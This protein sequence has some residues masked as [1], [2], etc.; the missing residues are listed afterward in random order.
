MSW[1]T[2]N[3]K[4]YENCD[5]EWEIHSEGELVEFFKD[6]D[7]D[8]LENYREIITER[9]FGK[10]YVHFYFGWV[11]SRGLMGVFKIDIEN[12]ELFL[13]STGN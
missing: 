12:E 7:A 1:K 11:E 9:V 10:N 4:K 6:D 13:F 5:D 3:E 2:L 8:M